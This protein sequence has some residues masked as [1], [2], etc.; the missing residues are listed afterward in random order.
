[1]KTGRMVQATRIN[2]AIMVLAMLGLFVTA[3]EVRANPDITPVFTGVTGV[4]PGPFTFNYTIVLGTAERAQPGAV[5]VAVT[6]PGVG[7]A[8]ASAFA[9]YFTIYDFTGFDG[10]HTDPAGWT[11]LS[12]DLGPTSTLVDP[13]D[14]PLIPNISWYRSGAAIDGAQVIAGFSANTTVGTTITT[15]QFSSDA[16]KLAPG[17]PQNLFAQ[18][19]I[20]FTTVPT[21]PP[22]DGVVPEPASLLLLGSG[23]AGLAGWRRWHTNRSKD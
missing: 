19:N 7:P 20:G 9:D 21:P 6:P 11:F 8:G 1:M 10:T 3:T 17:D 18:A 2:A 12:L 16:T 13:T 15:G 4:A 14:N 23:L 5:P 22:S